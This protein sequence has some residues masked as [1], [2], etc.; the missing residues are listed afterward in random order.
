MLYAGLKCSNICTHCL[1]LSCL[2]AAEEKMEDI[3]E[4]DELSITDFQ[5]VDSDGAEEGDF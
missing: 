4:P 2:N 3:D 5:E 1:G